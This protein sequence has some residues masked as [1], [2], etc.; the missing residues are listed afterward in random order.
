MAKPSKRHPGGTLTS[1][2]PHALWGGH[3][4]LNLQSHLAGNKPDYY[5]RLCLDC[6]TA[7]LA[8]LNQLCPKEG[9]HDYP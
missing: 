7:I 9:N 3:Y 1:Q 4:I 5:Y 8:S 6:T 2:C